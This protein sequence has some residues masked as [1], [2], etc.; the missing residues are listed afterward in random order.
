M[1]LTKEVF[2]TFSSFPSSRKTNAYK[3]EFDLKTDDE[4]A[5]HVMYHF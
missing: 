3:F 4:D 1:V 5:L 2:T